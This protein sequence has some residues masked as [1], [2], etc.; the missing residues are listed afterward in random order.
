MCMPVTTMRADS[1]EL[2]CTA[3]MTSRSFPKSARVPV[4]KR[5]SRRPGSAKVRPAH[6]RVR[7]QRPRDGPAEQALVVLGLDLA[8][9]RALDPD[10]LR[11]QGLT[12]GDVLRGDHAGVREVDRRLLL[13]ED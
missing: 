8:G 13:G 1:T 2:F 9:A 3:S 12:L 10:V 11:G 6:L 4:R 5:T 7:R